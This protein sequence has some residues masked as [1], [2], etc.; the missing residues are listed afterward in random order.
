MT[1][2][3]KQ[4][5]ATRSS[6]LLEL[7]H[8]D[9][10]GP[11]SHSLCGKSFF[12]TF[13]YNFSRYGYVYL[14]SHKSEALERFK[15]FKTEV[16]KQ[17]GKVI[18]IVRSDRGGE[19]YG[20]HGDLGQC[21]GP[22]A[23][24]L[25]SC[26]IKAQYTMPGT[27]EQNGVAERR[28]RTLMDMVRSMISRTKLP[29]SLWGE[30]LQTAMYILNRVPSKSVP[31]TPFELWTNRKPSLSH[32]KVWGC[33]SE[34]RVYNPHERKL[35]PRTTSG[36]FIGYPP[37]SKGFRFYCP[38]HHTSIVES[39]N[40][41]FLEDHIDSSSSQSSESLSTQSSVD[42]IILPIMQERITTI[43]VQGEGLESGTVAPDSA[44]VN[45]NTPETVEL[46]PIQPMPLR[47]SQRERRPALLDDYVVYSGEVD[48][49]IGEVTDPVTFLDVIHNPQ[50]DKWNISMKE[51]MLS[52]A[53]NGVWDLVELP[54]NFKPI[55]CKWV[56]KTKKDAKGK[57]E[58]FKARL[59]AKGYTQKE[60]VDYTETFSP[61]S[62]K[63]SFRIIMA[64][65]AHFN[66]ELQ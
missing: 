16:E 2:T 18:K 25:Q 6:D 44:V 59:V 66:L 24:F 36:F 7:I 57:I 13:I 60:G 10:S 56:F 11:Y 29:Q 50:Y 1:K 4:Q 32:L 51:E 23:K 47:R 53:N 28:N 37:A 8:T 19:Y 40:A 9:I 21:L 33:P 27:P 49:D 15:I 42:P 20:K 3:R 46:A 5:G 12:V 41:K 63:D 62:S 52:M 30:A 31:K 61:V 22:F 35:D 34:V 65:T 55:G 48:Y 26:G 43:P 39:L 58:R 38:G 64:L 14:I 17:L 54:E 45:E